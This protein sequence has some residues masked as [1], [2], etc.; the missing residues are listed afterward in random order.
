MRIYIAGPLFAK[1]ELEFN[2]RLDKFL[3]DLGF[4]TFLPQRDGYK[5]IDLLRNKTSKTEAIKL[6]FEK[7]IN[8]IKKSDILILIMDGRVPDEGASVELGAAYVLGKECIGLKTDVRSLL[9]GMDNP[10]ITGALHARIARNFE[11][12]RMHLEELK[13]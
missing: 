12:L 5:L 2:E 10:L 6:I 9:D 13:S 3:R 7:D 4:T 8:E 1:A 11:E